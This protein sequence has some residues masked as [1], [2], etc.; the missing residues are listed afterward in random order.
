MKVH[1][2]PE[3]DWGDVILITGFFCRVDLGPGAK[4]SRFHYVHQGRCSCQPGENCLAVKLVQSYLAG[5]GEAAPNPPDGF[6][7]VLPHSCP[8]CGAAIRPENR[9][10]SP[11]RGL[12]WRCQA[13]KGH[14]WQSMGRKKQPAC[15]CYAYPFA[16]QPGS[17]IC[18]GKNTGIP[19]VVIPEPA[20]A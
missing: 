16:H 3:E 2:L 7:A 6:Y 10:N 15:H 18:E 19:A 17:G 1:T 4:K 5:G 20:F 13:D 12:G 11:V 9:L 8:V 14:Y